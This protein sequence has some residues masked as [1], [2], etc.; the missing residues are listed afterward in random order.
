MLKVVTQITL[1]CYIYTDCQILFSNFLISVALVI[2]VVNNKH[3]HNIVVI[4]FAYA[5]HR[6]SDTLSKYGAFNITFFLRGDI[7]VKPFSH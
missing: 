2:V 4:L 6:K 7:K 1:L 3:N 5:S